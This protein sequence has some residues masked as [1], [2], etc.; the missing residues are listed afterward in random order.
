MPLWPSQI[1][2]KT[3]HPYELIINP[4]MSLESILEPLRLFKK[5]L[6]P[7][8]RWLTSFQPLKKNNLKKFLKNSCVYT[9]KCIYLKY[10]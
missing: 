5:K 7:E 4:C 10:K 1:L 2:S 8:N 3:L 9:L 6:I